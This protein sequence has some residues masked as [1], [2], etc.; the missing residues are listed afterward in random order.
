MSVQPNVRYQLVEDT[1][2]AQSF[3]EKLRR[4]V[5][6]LVWKYQRGLRG[7]A[8]CDV[9]NLNTYLLTWLPSAVR[10][11]RDTG[12]SYPGGFE[13]GRTEEE[14]DNTLTR[15]ADLL[16]LYLHQYNTALP[17]SKQGLE[18]FVEVFESLWD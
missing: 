3:R 16:E 6:R 9:W 10:Q 11:L 17:T 13:Y 8:D 4:Y 2:T 12:H 1:L 15:L 7:Y 18:L 5:L 14:W